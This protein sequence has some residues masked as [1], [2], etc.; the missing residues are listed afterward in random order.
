MK[1]VLLNGITPAEKIT[2]S[3]RAES[4]GIDGR[5]GT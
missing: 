2:F 3:E 4:G 1:A 5:H